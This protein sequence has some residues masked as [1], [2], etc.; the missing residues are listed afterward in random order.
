MKKKNDLAINN[1]KIAIVFFIF[2]AAVAGVS[3]IFKVITIV[4]DGKF[5]DSRRFTLTITDGKN[6]QALSLSGSTK[7]IVIFKLSKNIKSEDFG[8]FLEIPIDGFI[9]SSSLNLN[10]KVNSLFLKSILNYNN[11]K[12]NLTI[13][14]LLKLFAFAT[15]IPQGNINVK[16][17][18]QDLDWTD[19]DRIVGRLTSDELIEKDN[20]TIQVIN[21]T[22]KSGLGN[23]LARL[24]TNM[25][26]DVIIVATS[27]SPKKKS[28]I[29]YIGK[30]MYTV[31]RL[32]KIL[33]YDVIEE[34]NNAISDI[35]ITIGEDKANSS[36]F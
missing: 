14:D 21:G 6:L 9:A 5:D 8:R 1:T 18:P 19:A 36:P 30:K 2:L 17:I 13:I 24:I 31:E 22:N 34:N 29:S 10:Q 3:L 35:T 26:G 27:D 20:K 32:R 16:N 7:N 28:T 33:G 25:G 23:R 12:T 4:R 11:L 15:T